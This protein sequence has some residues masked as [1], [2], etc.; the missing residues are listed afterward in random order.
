MEFTLFIEIEEYMCMC[1]FVHR[2]LVWDEHV[3]QEMGRNIPGR[4]SP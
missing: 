3:N 1:G 4:V 2:Y